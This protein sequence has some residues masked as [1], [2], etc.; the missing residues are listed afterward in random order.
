MKGMNRQRR[1][2]KETELPWRCKMRKG[3]RGRETEVKLKL[4]FRC[5][6][7]SITVL[8]QTIFLLTG[9][10]QQKKQQPGTTFQDVF[11]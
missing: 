4:S 8:G 10:L 6:Y 9:K 7:S 11:F 1:K 2:N 5:D 3:D